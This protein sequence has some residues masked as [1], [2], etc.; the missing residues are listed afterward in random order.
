MPLNQAL[1]VDETRL[2]GPQITKQL[3]LFAF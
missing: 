1:A 3:E 2:D